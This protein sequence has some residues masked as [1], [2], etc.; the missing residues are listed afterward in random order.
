M[1]NSD[2]I[3]Q[4]LSSLPLDRIAA[5]LGEDPAQVRAAAERILPALIAGMGANAEDPAGRDS[6][7]QAVA[8]HDPAFV[9]G[10]VDVEAID[11]GDGQQITRHVFGENEDAVA[12]RLGGLG[13]GVGLV[14]KLLPILAPLVMS[15]LAGRLR[16]GGAGTGDTARSGASQGG[17][18]EQVLRQ[19]LG[20]GQQPGGGALG[21]LLGGLLGG[22]RR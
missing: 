8:Q 3:S 16:Q 22:G 15:W 6:L 11:T 21:D 4:L 18:L 14:R 7:A 1:T 20:G 2:D 17:L 13:G 19:V 12:A 9:E 10:G 5:R